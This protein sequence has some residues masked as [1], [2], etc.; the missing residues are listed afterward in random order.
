MATFLYAY[1]EIGD[2][3]ADIEPYVNHAHDDYVELW[4]EGGLPAAALIAAALGL[5]AWQLRKNLRGA[6]K[7]QAQRC[8][9][10]AC[11]LGPPLSLLLIALHSIV[12]YPLRTLTDRHLA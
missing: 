10:G 3:S 12:D 4:L 8:N 9:T 1:D 6:R 7:R 2:E 11:G 5:I